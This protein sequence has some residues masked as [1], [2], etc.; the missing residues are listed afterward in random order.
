MTFCTQHFKMHFLE[1][2]YINFDLHFTV[3]KIQIDN[4]PVLVQIMASRHR[5]SDKPLLESMMVSLLTH[6]CVIQLQWFKKK[7]YLFVC[8]SVFVDQ[9]FTDFFAN[10]CQTLTLAQVMACCLV[11]PSHCLNQCWFIINDTLKNIH[12]WT[13][14]QNLNIIIP[15]YSLKNFACNVPASMC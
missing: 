15:R 14:I 7:T 4:I 6:I 1:W 10:L 9:L 8:C 3:P 11:A 13:N 5:P 2:R 12:I